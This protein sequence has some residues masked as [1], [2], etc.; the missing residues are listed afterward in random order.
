VWSRCNRFARMVGTMSEDTSADA[1]SVYL[2]LK[3]V[4][5]EQL[6][7]AGPEIKQT[8]ADVRAASR[9]PV[10]AELQPQ[11]GE[12]ANLE[13]D[14]R[15]AEDALLDNWMRS[16]ETAN[17]KMDGPETSVSGRIATQETSRN[18][19]EDAPQ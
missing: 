8:V 6:L 19:S 7:G 1:L 14:A 2:K 17:T 16:A 4:D 11:S 18:N 12:H 15:Q 9:V 3:A 5:D 13:T 10:D